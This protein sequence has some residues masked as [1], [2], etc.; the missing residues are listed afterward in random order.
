MNK[1]ILKFL[2][3]FLIGF[4]VIFMAAVW[5][6][7][8]DHYVSYAKWKYYD[9]NNVTCSDIYRFNQVDYS[10]RNKTWSV[11]Y[12]F[13]TNDIF[14]TIYPEVSDKNIKCIYIAQGQY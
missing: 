9:G 10:Q 5:F 2:I 4:V 1:K 8:S 11:A 13:W 3:G 6:K 14:L 12:R 7:M